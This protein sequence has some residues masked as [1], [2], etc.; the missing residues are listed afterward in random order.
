MNGGWFLFKQAGSGT[1]MSENGKLARECLPPSAQPQ[2]AAKL[3]SIPA[4]L[5]ARDRGW[6]A[7]PLQLSKSKIAHLKSCG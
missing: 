5:N 7:K 3:Q 4:G 2:I 1:E 6:A